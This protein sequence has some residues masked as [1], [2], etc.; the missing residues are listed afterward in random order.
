MPTSI[1]VLSHRF[2]YILVFD[3]VSVAIEADVQ[4][5]V[6]RTDV[7]FWALPTLYEIDH[8]L[9]LAGSRFEHLVAFLGNSASESICGF[10]V[11][12]SLTA[13][14]VAWLVSILSILFLFPGFF[15]FRGAFIDE[16]KCFHL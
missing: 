12:T 8:T 10:D 7:L 6:C 14:P 2:L 15:C 5:I 3:V 11:S 1:E 4:G 13:S 9:R 16:D